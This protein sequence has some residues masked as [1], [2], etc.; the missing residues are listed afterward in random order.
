[1]RIS[2]KSKHVSKNVPELVQLSYSKYKGQK[3]SIFTLMLPGLVVFTMFTIYPILKLFYISFF[4]W[5]MGMGQKSIFIGF[6]NYVRVFSDPTF[7]IAFQNTLAYA[8]ITVPAQIILGL[9]VA[10]FI[11]AIPRCQ[12]IFR[13]LYYLPVITSWVI[14][15]LIFKYIFNTEGYLNYFL[16]DILHITQHNIKWLDKRN[17]GM[18]VAELLGIW[19]GIGWNMVVFLAALQAVPIQLYEAAE[20]DGCGSVKKFFN[21]T[22]PSIKNTILFAVVMISIGA[23]NVFTSIQLMTDGEPAHQTEV[24]LTWMYHKAFE[25]GD[26]GY[27]A[28]LSYIISMVISTI[29]LIQFKVFKTDNR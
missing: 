16:K 22:L 29:T 24:L 4:D 13:T 20:I 27:S 17:T 1:M 19:K 26:F 28:A 11:N 21:I 14:V 18:F 15:S 10:V 7:K 12:V 3:I 6:N 9:L 5:N 25:A 2:K 8:V 23:F